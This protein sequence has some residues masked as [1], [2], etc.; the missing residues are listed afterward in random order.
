MDSFN[1]KYGDVM[2]HLEMWWLIGSAL[3]FWGSGPGFESDISHNGPTV[4][5]DSGLSGN[6]RAERKTYF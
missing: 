5:Q 3:D 1:R 2:V 4:H 6:L